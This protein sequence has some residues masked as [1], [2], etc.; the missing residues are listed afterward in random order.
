MRDLGGLER[1]RRVAL[2]PAGLDAESE[3]RAEILQALHRR[4]RG[5]LP[6]SAELA[7]PFDGQVAELPVP[8]LGAERDQ[9]ADQQLAPFLDGGGRQIPNRRLLEELVDGVGDRREFRLEDA[10]AAGRLPL[11]G[12]GGGGRPVARVQAAAD[13]F[14]AD[15]ALNPDGALAP[16]PAIALGG[17]LAAAEV[18]TVEREVALRHASE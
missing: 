1:R 5:V 10:D 13:G 12:D 16:G 15:R 14:A 3:K 7:E 4:E 9:L 17:V 2:D 6:P 8:A 11:V 18:A